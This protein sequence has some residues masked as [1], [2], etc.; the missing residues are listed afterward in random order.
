MP[1]SNSR[2]AATNPK[3]RNCT[4]PHAELLHQKAAAQQHGT[5]HRKPLRGKSKRRPRA[6][7]RTYNTTHFSAAQTATATLIGQQGEGQKNQEEQKANSESTAAI[8]CHSRAR[9]IARDARSA[10]ARRS[11]R[12]ENQPRA[13]RGQKQGLT[14]NSATTR[15]IAWRIRV[16]R[17]H[18]SRLKFL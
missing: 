17:K 9:T 11:N 15:E 14:A 8:Q 6:R 7:T 3:I 13:W 1:S 16:E 12:Q 2:L 10:R 5:S 4:F 18:H